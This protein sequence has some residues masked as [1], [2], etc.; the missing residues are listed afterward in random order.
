MK[1]VYCIHGTFNSGGME[2]VIS[3]KVNYLVNLPNYEV[4]IVTTGQRG[5]PHFYEISPKVK[6]IDLDVNYSE[7]TD[8]NPIARM[9]ESGIKYFRHKARLKKL[10]FKLKVDIV[11]SMF[12]ND[13]S[14]LHKIKDGSKKV[15]EIHFSREFRLL[16]NRK[17][18]VRLM[19][20]YVTNLNDRIVAKY[21]RFVVLTHQDKQSWKSQKNISVIY[22]SVTN[23]DN[24]IV[25]SLDNK[26]VL[27]IGRLTYQKNLELLIELWSKV[28][29]KFPD[30]IL[31]IVG[32]GDSKEL[33]QTIFNN[34]LDK[35]IE[36]VPSTNS[37]GDYYKES[38]LY[39]MTSR[40]EGLP[41]VLLEA[42]NYGL[43]IVSFDC[44]CG[45]REIINNGENGYLIEN[46]NM[47]DFV[48]K[49]SRLIENERMRNVFG[50][51]AKLNSSNFS[52]EI[53]MKQWVTLFEEVVNKKE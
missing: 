30:W 36:L 18:I 46:G 52:E 25:S 14:F 10:L 53:I 50:K 42:Q 13:V 15:L 51:K 28:S 49:V 27:A 33:Q 34:S 38:S 22:N 23:S 44:K 21:D 31:T 8:G 48:E 1:I 11:I 6:C 37:I 45:P 41:M 5:R 2:R 43:P 16:A 40:Y 4:Y 29:K 19:D 47:E 12:T 7:T 20:I 39:L 35:F 32:T 26:K 24:K 9:I 17:G 3:N